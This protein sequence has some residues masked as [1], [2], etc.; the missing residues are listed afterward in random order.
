MVLAICGSRMSSGACALPPAQELHLHHSS[1][2]WPGL[3]QVQHNRPAYVY[4]VH[5]VLMGHGGAC[6]LEDA[7]EAGD[8][9]PVGQRILLDALVQRAQGCAH[10]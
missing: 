1:V 10:D 4:S 9:V 6:L 3:T 7:D 5:K 8:E 2:I